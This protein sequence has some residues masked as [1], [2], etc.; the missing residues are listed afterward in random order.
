MPVDV[1]YIVGCLILLCCST[2]AAAGGIGGGAF[3]VPILMSVFGYGYKTAVSLSLCTVF[4]NVLSQFLGWLYV[5]LY[6]KVILSSYSIYC[7]YTTT[8]VLFSCM[9]DYF[10]IYMCIG[11]PLY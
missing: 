8:F 11:I 4:G 3:N 5:E 6:E 1:S 7:F 9:P 10:H 2:L